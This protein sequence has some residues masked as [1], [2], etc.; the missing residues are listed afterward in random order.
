MFA[1]IGAPELIIILAIVLLVFGSTRLPRLAKS[2]GQ[3]HKE[4]KKGTREGDPN[5]EEE[6]ANEDTK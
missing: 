4:Y 5:S 2:L 3:A 1:T 6:L